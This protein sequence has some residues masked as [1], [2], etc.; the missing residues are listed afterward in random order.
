[1]N[2]RELIEALEEHGDHLEV[3]L[4]YEDGERA[5]F[6]E[7]SSTDVPNPYYQKLVIGLERIG[8]PE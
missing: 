1:M 5:T 2:V 7:I 8:Q 6:F 3:V 4:E